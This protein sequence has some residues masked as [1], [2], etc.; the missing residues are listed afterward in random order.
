[1]NAIAMG[2]LAGL[3]CDRLWRA[4]AVTRGWLYT[5]EGVGWALIT[6]I[7]S[8]PPWGWLHDTIRFLARH[9]L[10]DTVLPLGVCFVMVAT[11]LRR[12]RGGGWLTAPLRWF[13]RH[14]YEV[15]LT[16]E[17]LVILGHI[18][19]C[20]ARSYNFWKVSQ[21]CADAKLSFIYQCSLHPHFWKIRF[22]S[23]DCRKRTNARA[24][25]RDLP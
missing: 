22:P 4:A 11:V 2:C 14:S 20:L 12:S 1:M 21:N 5:A 9:D 18:M 16:H 19:D 13:G 6:W 25:G 15:Y 23:G 17:F 7:A 24:S 10:N 3:L 8:W